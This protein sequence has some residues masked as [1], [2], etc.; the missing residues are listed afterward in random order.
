M[1][2]EVIGTTLS[3]L[4]QLAKFAIVMAVFVGVPPLARRMRLP[5]QVGLILMGVVL[6]PHGTGLFGES[7]PIADFFSELGK[8]LLVFSIGLE[9]DLD[10]VRRTRSR[11]IVLGTLATLLPVVLGAAC[12]LLLGAAVLPALA[13]G[14]LIAPHSL[15]SI[16]AARRPSGEPVLVAIGA[17]VLSNALSLLAFGVLVTTFEHGFSW[18]RLGVQLAGI[19]LLLPL[20][21]LVLAGAGARV[22]ERVRGNE[23]AYFVVLLAI[24]AIAGLLADAVRLPEIVGAFLAGLAVNRAVHT[25]PARER[26]QFLGKALFIPSFFVVTGFLL[27]PLDIARYFAT[28]LRLIAGLLLALIAGRAIAA[29]LVGVA[30]G[31]ARATRWSLVGLTLPL[32]EAAIAATVVGH[33][34]LG[35]SGERMLDPSVLRAVLVA[36]VVT[37]IVGPTITRRAHGA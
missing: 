26:V 33:Q 16:P 17:S 9:V 4:P 6:G 34:A 15:V 35:G 13:I 22:L 25:H 2:P 29:L 12:A 20:V 1:L 3:S 37:S 14:C 31:Y 21:L 32:G 18:P 11:A 30:F 8:L 28:D 19:A 36:L 24:M 5:E 7:R 27:D 23:A 10:H